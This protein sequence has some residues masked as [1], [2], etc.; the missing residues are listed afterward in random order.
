MKILSL[1]LA[2]YKTVGCDYEGESGRHGF[3]VSCR[4]SAAPHCLLRALP[5]SAKHFRFRV[6]IPDRS[7]VLESSFYSPRL[8]S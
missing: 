6:L 4:G 3:R 5:L 1:A 8:S 7:R 2:K